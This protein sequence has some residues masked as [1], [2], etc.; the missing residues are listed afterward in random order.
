MSGLDNNIIISISADAPAV[1]AAGFGVPCLVAAAGS[2]GDG[3]E[4]RV[5]FYEQG[6]TAPAD[7]LAAGDITAAVKDAI[8]VAFSQKL[9]VAKVAVAR[10]DTDQ[11]QVE[12]FTIGAGVAPDDVFSITIGVVTEQ[13]VAS[14]AEDAAAVA[15]ALRAL[16]TASL[17]G[18]HTITGAAAEVTVTALVAGE[19]FDVSSLYTATGGGTS[20]ITESTT[21]PNLS[22]KT[23]L[24][25][26]VASEPGFYAMVPE[27]RV[28][29]QLERFAA[30]VEAN[31]RLGL[32]QTSDANVK[33]T[34]TTD[35]ATALKQKSYG[36]TAVVY[37][38]NNTE[39]CA[40]AWEAFKL[41]AD[42][43]LRKTNWP[44]ATLAGITIGT[45]SATEKANIEG[46]NANLY[47]DFFKQ[48]S[49]WRGTLAN[50]RHIDEL[51]TDDW[52]TARMQERFAQLFLNTSNANRML[53]LTDV[54]ISSFVEAALDV[55]N[56][57]VK[58]GH[59]V[60]GSISVTAPK[61]SELTASQKAA[62][63]IPIEFVAQRAVGVDKATI[64]GSVVIE[65]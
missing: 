30:W 47:W 55:L 6:S 46:K 51:I 41:E 64:S 26:V 33:T 5:R 29:L 65:L 1:A 2:L 49:T 61:A 27:T 9:H 25:A 36:R 31:A 4:E 28:K 23:E 32:A 11:A 14:A 50:G 10:I 45:F 43:D 13:Y 63:T 15:A 3:F 38:A 18:T 56:S 12:K 40:F 39:H 42:P 37:H 59:F 58:P 53:A 48:G 24:D 20:S 21:T 19:A 8:D 62:K 7:D 22:I 34:A 17:A 16:L 52:L 44:Y 57:G 54:G 35:V 60:P